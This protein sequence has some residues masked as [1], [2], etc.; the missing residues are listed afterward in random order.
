MKCGECSTESPSSDLDVAAMHR[1]E[2][3]SDPEDMQTVLGFACPSCGANGVL[4]ASHGP[5]ASEQDDEF[6]SG[7]TLNPAEMVDPVEAEPAP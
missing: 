7:V 4:V 2:G 3:A 1:M 5:A 6:L